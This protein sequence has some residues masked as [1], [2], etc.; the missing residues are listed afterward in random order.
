MPVE[1]FMAGLFAEINAS[2]EKMKGLGKPRGGGRLKPAPKA[3]KPDR[4]EGE[5]EVPPAKA[6]KETKERAPPK[7]KVVPVPPASKF[8]G[9]R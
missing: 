3:E 1:D 2:K 6:P 9:R 8:G 4:E 5:P 7:P